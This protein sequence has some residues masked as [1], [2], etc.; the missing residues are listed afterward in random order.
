MVKAMTRLRVPRGVAAA[1]LLAALVAGGGF[2]LYGLRS[3]AA[4]IIDKLP[5]A[6]RRV[7]QALENDR[8]K[9]TTAIQQVQKAATEL[10]KAAG[11]AATPPPPPSGVTRVQVESP[12]FDVSDY[13]VWGSLGIVAASVSSC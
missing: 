10:E 7:R 4:A 2:L 6:A 8:P 1:I 5:Q 11:A 3:D 13:V 12:P 9:A